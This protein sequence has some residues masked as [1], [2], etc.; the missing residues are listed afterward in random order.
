M[1]RVEIEV[2]E[3]TQGR[4][5]F[6]VTINGTEYAKGNCGTLARAAQQATHYAYMELS[7]PSATGQQEA[8]PTLNLTRP[9]VQILIDAITGNPYA[10]MDKAQREALADLR[11]FIKWTGDGK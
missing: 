11:T 7:D 6:V 4:A 9:E 5:N 1:R 2:G 10:R 8:E 3:S